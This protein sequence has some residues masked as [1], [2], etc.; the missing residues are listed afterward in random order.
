MFGTGTYR[1]RECNA[2]ILFF[3][4][5]LLQCLYMESISSSI[6]SS[7]FRS[8]FSS[9]DR[10]PR[11]PRRGTRGR[12]GTELNGIV[13]T[14]PRR[15][16]RRACLGRTHSRARA[17]GREEGRESDALGAQPW[18]LLWPRQRQRERSGQT[19]LSGPPTGAFRLCKR[20][21]YRRLA[22]EQTVSLEPPAK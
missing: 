7:Y 8:P 2:Y 18:R 19:L 17:W 9:L 15:S 12:P 3:T 22:E 21:R 16:R 6:F 4:F 13:W 20:R 10:L 14:A 1:S 5:L 11:G